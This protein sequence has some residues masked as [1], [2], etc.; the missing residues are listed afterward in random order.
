MR[1]NKLETAL[2]RDRYIACLAPPDMF[3]FHVHAMEKFLISYKLHVH[4]HLFVFQTSLP[5]TMY[6]I[7]GE[8]CRAR[9]EA[10]AQC[11]GISLLVILDSPHFI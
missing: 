6:I 3:F 11:K 5:P 10:R 4:V 2:S 7:L 9:T 1:A 8:E